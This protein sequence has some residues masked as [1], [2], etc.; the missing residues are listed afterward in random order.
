MPDMEDRK[1]SSS[2]LESSQSPKRAHIDG[3]NEDDLGK[4]GQDE[5]VKFQ[6]EAIFRQMKVHLRERDLLQNK[7]N[8]IEP[9]FNNLQKAFSQLDTWWDNLLCHLVPENDANG[10]QTN[11]GEDVPKTL[12]LKAVGKE[13]EEKPS[14]FDSA[15][16]N[17]GEYI[18]SKLSP[19]FKSINSVA[20]PDAT[21]LQDS[22]NH[23]SASLNN[24]RADND[25]LKMNRDTLA[26]QLNNVTEKY[27]AAE[28][29]LERLESP[30]LKRIVKAS[31]SNNESTENGTAENGNDN[32]AS[33]PKQENHDEKSTKSGVSEEDVEQ[34]K[35]AL[36]ESQAV[37]SK[38]KEQL[39]QQEH[40]I[41]TLN[42]HI[43]QL[44]AR[45]MNLSEDDL[46]QSNAFQALKMANNDLKYRMSKLDHTNEQ[47]MKEKRELMEEREEY[48][49]KVK[50]E[51]QEQ[52]E[53]LEKQMN[54]LEQDVARIRAARDDILSE[55][56]TKKA[57]EHERDKSIEELQGLLEVRDSRIKTLEEKINRLNDEGAA[58]NGTDSEVANIEN[59]SIDELKQLV[60]KLQRQ[61]KN[62][63]GEI[64]GLEQAYAK[65]HQK[66]TSKALDITEREAKMH[67]LTV[68]KSK[69]DEKY[70]GAMRSKD[71]LTNESNRLKN[72]LAK[73]SELV[74]QL[75]ETERQKTNRITELQKQIQE[76]ANS[77]MSSEKE[78]QSIRAK[79]NEKDHRI[80]SA[81][82]HI[83]KL[84]EDL[85][86]KDS[87][88]RKEVESRRGLEIQIEKLKRQV[89]TKRLTSTGGKSGSDAEE[90][91]E[92][93]RSIALCSLCSK[94]WK[95]TAIKSC[96]HVFCSDCAKDRLNVRLRK[97][98][99]CN[100]Q[101]S[102]N[103]L[104]SIHL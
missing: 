98:P 70:F 34:A 77:R 15:L 42:N 23:V 20:S 4:L 84:Y 91:I 61:N 81:N 17:K 86:Q 10:N 2:H 32:T 65:A 66:A 16:T 28:K 100:K 37:V 38:Q 88:N 76:N 63:A 54:K 93:L 87:S 69:A 101:Y 59:A 95:D 83:E 31:T 82:K 22:L 72:Q 56:N 46:R 85:K 92:A 8:E 9:Q 3:D 74:Q 90:Q 44:S 11:N 68:E 13:G 50:T 60:Q 73:S 33:E 39:D 48:L 75:R 52:K 53:E 25:N 89:E 99:M 6:K 40:E 94:N 47:L 71:M 45:F 79:L 78:V 58:T 7:I 41:T 5:I 102:F 55:L 64:P 29:K 103:D 30:S 57:S 96:G 49:H 12:L 14:S 21:K 80:D 67:K 26:S 104:L 35:S 27:L 62:L 1:R 18:K 19:I 36:E 24:I 43:R 97:C 51:Y